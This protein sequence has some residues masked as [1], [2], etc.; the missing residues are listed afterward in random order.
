MPSYPWKCPSCGIEKTTTS[1]IADKPA[2]SG[3]LECIHCDD[4]M[5]QQ[6]ALI[7]V[8]GDEAEWLRSVTDVVDSDGGK[9]CQE[10]IDTPS[11][12]NYEK[13]QKGEGLRPLE[14]GEEKKKVVTKKEKVASRHRQVSNLAKQHQDRQAMTV[15]SAT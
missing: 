15:R 13:W 11:R 9:H 3:A 12:S 14:P 5:V 8:H 6:V 2:A 4:F 10:F 7:K 1:T